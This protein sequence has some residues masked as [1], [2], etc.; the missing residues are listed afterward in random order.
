MKPGLRVLDVGCGNGRYLT[1][2]RSLGASVGDI[3]G[4][5]LV[6]SWDRLVDEV[7]AAVAAVIRRDGAF[8]VQGDT[9]AFV[10]E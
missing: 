4:G 8:V 2:L 3:Y 7:R 5:D 6:Y 9:G 1:A 10:C